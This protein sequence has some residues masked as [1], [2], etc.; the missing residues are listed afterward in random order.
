MTEQTVSKPR[1][2]KVHD[3]GD[4]YRKQVK[5]KV[6]LEGKWLKDAGYQA[7]QYVQVDNPSPGVLIITCLEAQV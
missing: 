1:T 7:G 3:I 5:L 6:A 4:H 2:L